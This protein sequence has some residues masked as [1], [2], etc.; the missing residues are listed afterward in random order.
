MNADETLHVAVAFSNPPRWRARRDNM[1]EF[2]RRM[3]N[4]PN[5]KL[6]VGEVTYGDLPFE[7]T[8][9]DCPT[10]FQFRVKDQLWHKENIINVLASKFDKDWKYG[11]YVDS[12]LVFSKFDWASEAIKL[13][14]HYKWVQLFSSLSDLDSNHNV[15][16]MRRSFMWNYI[17]NR[18]EGKVNFSAPGGGWGFTREAFNATGG[19]LDTCILGSGDHHMIVGLMQLS[20]TTPKMPK[21][22]Q[23]AQ[24][25]NKLAI[26]VWQKRAEKL[27]RNIGCLNCHLTH[28]WHGPK[29]DRGYGFRWE[30]LNKY[31]FNPYTDLFRD[32]NGLY[33]LDSSKYDFR[34]EI[35]TYFQ[36][37][38]EDMPTPPQVKVV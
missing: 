28:Y 36:L 21:E 31:D 29:A 3:A 37:R 17:Y 2:R 11:G 15:L 6:Y 18:Q 1:L 4:T 16:D 13:L 25:G 34:D 10:D 19:L 12:D 33:Q 22:T 7:V 27:E 5:V 38:N 32:S 14:Q 26:E 24:G 9:E 20:K 8:S 23:T 35:R 30:L